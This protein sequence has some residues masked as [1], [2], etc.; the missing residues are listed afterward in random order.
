MEASHKTHRPH[1]KVGKDAEEEDCRTMSMDGQKMWLDLHCYCLP[2]CISLLFYNN[3]NICAHA[4]AKPSVG[5]WLSITIWRRK[6]GRT[7]SS[8]IRHT[9]LLQ[10]DAPNYVTPIIYVMCH[11]L[12]KNL[13][14]VLKAS[15]ARIFLRLMS[16]SVSSRLPSNLHFFHFSLPCRII[17]YSSVLDSLITRLRFA[18]V[19]GVVSL[20]YVILCLAA[21]AQVI[22][23]AYFGSI[24]K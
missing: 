16:F 12:S 13:C 14:S 20:I 4:W 22:S 1:I 19:D 24:S 2:L 17:S 3:V 6:K 7:S 18:R 11:L 21:V 10:H 8:S 5:N 9:L 23:S 15:I